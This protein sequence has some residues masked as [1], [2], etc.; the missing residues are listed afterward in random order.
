MR[1]KR[2]LTLL[3]SLSCLLS[4][5]PVTSV[6]AAGYSQLLE[7]VEAQYDAYAASIAQ[8]N[9]AD[10]GMEQLLNHALRGKHYAR[11]RQGRHRLRA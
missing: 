7:Q 1:I 11:K 2:F 10:D 4:V 5:L 6:N 8:P 3:L 9:A